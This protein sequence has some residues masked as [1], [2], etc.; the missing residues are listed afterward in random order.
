[1][2]GITNIHPDTV[3]ASLLAKGGRSNRLT[4]LAKVHELCRKQHEAGSR[5]FTLPSIGRLIEAEGIMKGR[6]LYN[7]QSLD[8]RVLIEAWAAYAG[9]AQSKPVKT[10]ASHD[11]LMRIEDPAIRSIMQGIISERDKL[12]AQVNLLKACNRA[13]HVCPADAG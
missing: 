5:A 10:L 12:R 9:P 4:N 2:K 7:A 1:M 13:Q 8:Y 3:V 11:Y 6:A